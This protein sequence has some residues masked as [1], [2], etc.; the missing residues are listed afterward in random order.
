MIKKS[1][2]YFEL[3]DDRIAKYP[4]GQRD[5]SKLL[6]YKDGKINHTVFGDISK[7]LLADSLIIRNNA[8]VIPARLY[9]KRN[10]GALIEILLLEPILPSNYEKAF[11]ATSV[12][13]WKC[14][15]GNSK[16]WKDEECV[17][18]VGYE[19]RMT[20]RP[21][22][23]VDRLV[24]FTWQSGKPFSEMLDEIGELPLPPYLNRDTEEADAKTYQTVFASNAGSVAAPTAGLHFTPE[25]LA[26][27]ADNGI[28]TAE[29]TL[30]VGAG[31][32]LPVKEE[33]VEDHDMH[34]EHFEVGFTTLQKLIDKP[35]RVAVGTTSLRVLES[36]Y[37]IGVQ[38]SKADTR[39]IVN[40]LEPYEVVANMTYQAAIEHILHYMNTKNMVILQAATEIMILPHYKPKSIS[41]LVTNF[42]LPEST[43]LLLIASVVGAEWKYIYEE[44]LK[45]DYRFLSY[46][47]SSLLFVE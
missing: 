1:D 8:K 36:L 7:L 40:K 24:E 38:L 10:T 22:D 35:M 29:V 26:D 6:V 45:M 21:V 47:D 39:L 4:L 28:E 20:A 42:H 17:G 15:I 44:A 5:S 33:N 27:I 9:F 41:A 25:V 32:F 37:W 18:L 13:Q 3:N 34:K 16:K 46:G 43:L 11:S 23:R 19:K 12:C 2:F 30:H 14:I 31:T